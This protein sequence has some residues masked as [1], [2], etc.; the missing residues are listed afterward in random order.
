MQEHDLDGRSSR[1]PFAD[2]WS[3]TCGRGLN[4]LH[5]APGRASAAL[6]SKGISRWPVATA[7]A[8]VI[9]SEYP[10]MG[11]IFTDGTFCL[12]VFDNGT[13]TEPV[14]YTVTIRHY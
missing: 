8:A 4:P 3:R 13:V 1:R 12:N 7:P 2:S 10:T 5:Y 6:F 14:N 11:G 9:G